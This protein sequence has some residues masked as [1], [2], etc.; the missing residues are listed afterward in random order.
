[1]RARVGSVGLKSLLEQLIDLVFVHAAVVEVLDSAKWAAHWAYD[2]HEGLVLLQLLHR[3]VL[4][5]FRVEVP[6][7]AVVR[8]DRR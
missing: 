4:F 8:I 2:Q 5:I 3:L 7:L 1:M 6:W